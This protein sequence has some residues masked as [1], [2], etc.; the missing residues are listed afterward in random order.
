MAEMMRFHVM[1][2]N[3]FACDLMEKNELDVF[4]VHYYMSYITDL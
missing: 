1:E 2:A 4:D 3:N